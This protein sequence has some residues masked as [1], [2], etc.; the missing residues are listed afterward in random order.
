MVSV[1]SLVELPQVSVKGKLLNSIDHWKSVGAPDL[2]LNI[3]RDGYKIPFISTPSRH[4]YRNNA[5]AVKEAEAILELLRD[6]CSEELFSP[7]DI[8][9]PLSVSVQSSGK[10]KLILDMSI[11]MCTSRNLNV[12]AC[13][14]LGVPFL[15]NILC[16][17][18][19]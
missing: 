2:I 19:I 5:S 13:I 18:L 1:R 15:K 12:K 4:H 17:R 16:F 10:K 6:N 9:N 7:P 3:I 11:C 8:I 14:P